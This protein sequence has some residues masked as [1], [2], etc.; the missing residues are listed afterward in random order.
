MVI[1]RKKDKRTGLSYKSIYFK[2]LSF[3]CLNEFH[4]LFYSN[5]TK[6]IPSNIKDL[7]TSIGLAHLIMGDGYFDTNKQTIFLCTENYSFDEVNL[8][9]EALNHKFGL[10][11]TA[12]KRELSNGAIR[13][14]IRFSKSS[15]DKLKT[16]VSKFV[17][18]EMMYKLGIEK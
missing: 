18:Q 11:A 2:T 6:C 13:W 16:L 8:L 4:D 5:N 12:N 17:I 7:L 15:L 1:E 10:M 14:I 3:L 9:I